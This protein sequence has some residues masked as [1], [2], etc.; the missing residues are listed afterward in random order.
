MAGSRRGAAKDWVGK[1][2]DGLGTPVT[3]GAEESTRRAEL[4]KGTRDI[5]QGLGGSQDFVFWDVTR[6]RGLAL[7]ASR[8]EVSQPRLQL[9]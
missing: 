6:T 8:G 3:P 9:E 5:Q 1:A 2:L 7:T 4:H